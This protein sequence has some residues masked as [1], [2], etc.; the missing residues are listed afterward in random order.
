MLFI[1][2]FWFFV[3]LTVLVNS[4]LTVFSTLSLSEFSSGLTSSTISEAFC[5]FISF[6]NIQPSFSPSDTFIQWLI[7]VIF[8]RLVPWDIL[9]ISFEIKLG[10]VLKLVSFIV[11][12]SPSSN[13]S[14]LVVLFVSFSTLLFTLFVIAFSIILLFFVLLLVF[15]LILLDTFSFLLLVV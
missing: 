8:F 11:S 15:V 4:L 12:I 1:I 2:L 10:E 5:D 14:L 3:S 9:L 6:S 7:W 13:G